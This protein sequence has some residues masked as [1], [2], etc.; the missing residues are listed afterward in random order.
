MYAVQLQYMYIVLLST[1][2][3]EEKINSDIC[4]AASASATLRR[5]VSR[6]VRSCSCAKLLIRERNRQKL[7]RLIYDE[8]RFAAGR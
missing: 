1:C 4:F 6:I 8:R 3:I 7:A 2:F 5:L